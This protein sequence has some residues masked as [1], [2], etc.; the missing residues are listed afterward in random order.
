MSR[1]GAFPLGR[2]A[3]LSGSAALAA[4]AF[5]PRLARADDAAPAAAS[6]PATGGRVHGLSA[7]GDLAYP[8]G[9][10]HFSYVNPAA[11]KGGRFSQTGDVES[12]NQNFN[13][14]N[15]LNFLILKG[16]GAMGMQMTF[17]TLMVRAFDE[18]DAVYGLAADSVTVSEDGLLYRFHLRPGLTFHDGSALTAADV[19]FSL[20]TLKAKGH[21]L[22]ARDLADMVEAVAEDP[23]TVAVRFV[24]G[25]SRE[26]PLFVATLPILSAAFYGRVPF[27]QTSLEVPLGSGPYKVGRFESGR[28]IEFQRVADWWGA[29]LPVARGQNNF[30]VVRYDYF[31][32]RTVAFEAFKAQNFLFREE[33]TSRVWA[34]GYD[35]PAVKDGRIVRF[36][37]PDQT[38]S[39]TQGWFINT[40][41]KKLADPRTRQA[42]GLAFD[43]DWVNTNLMFGAYK[44]TTSWF[45]NSPLAADG[46]P[47]PE[48]LAL[49]EPLRARVP[50]A[51]FGPALL[52]PSY[53]EPGADRV[54]L[55]AA[56]ELLKAAGWV[57]KGR[58]LVD[59]DGQPFTIEF[60]DFEPG[61]EPH[62]MK[63][64]DNLKRLGIDASIRRVDPA[65]YQSRVNSF[66][67][68]LTGRR[69]SMSTTP[70][71]GLIQ[72][73]GSSSA[74][75]DGSLNLAGIAD[76]A[77]DA[78]LAAI[79]AA[80]TRGE[81][82]TA[83]RAL[84]RVLRANYYW[85]PQWNKNTH[86]LA[87]WDVFGHPEGK[88]L[89]DRGTPETWWWDA[90]RARR[91]GIAP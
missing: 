67:F 35:F 42:L 14:F 29:D 12:Y 18:P 86:W 81:L 25:R 87:V 90:D 38:P 89:Y 22:I 88:P 15:S 73:F 71:Q 4:T 63:F 34:T 17:A 54:N 23:A 80:P 37:I 9:F 32:D 91:L 28:F 40:R 3:F 68:D 65:Q 59:A 11:P 78:L 83:A 52:P 51:V 53:A 57:A 6:T 30:E 16:D 13:T 33:F 5:A 61:L 8:A 21:P 27:D 46:D 24:P 82:T 60:L 76:P 66:D 74:H 55:K 1:P 2:R 20:T 56:S 36:E 70:G 44:R 19:A 7:F 49:L 47:S 10:P 26:L 39:G 31:R 75:V 84:D 48:E 79:I 62:T 50:E 58:Q 41:R 43:F 72:I 69:F 64:I 77:V 45:Q 85:V